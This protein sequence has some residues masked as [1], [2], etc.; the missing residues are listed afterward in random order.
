MA[1]ELATVGQL[2]VWLLK[3]ESLEIQK[4]WR[5]LPAAVRSD[6]IRDCRFDGYRGQAV[7]AAVV[8]RLV[9]EFNEIGS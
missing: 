8:A 4:Y 7:A 1:A 6:Y 9:S 2:I 5:D 3:E